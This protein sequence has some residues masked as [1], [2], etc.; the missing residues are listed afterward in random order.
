MGH[1]MDAIDVLLSRD[2]A[3][4]PPRAELASWLE[5]AARA[6]APPALRHEARWWE[7]HD[8]ALRS[9]W[10]RVTA[11]AGEGFGEPFSEREAVRLAL[12]H[13]ISGDVEE[14]QHVLAQAIQW[15]SDEGL[16]RRFADTCAAEGLAEA[17]GF[18]RR[19]AA[20]P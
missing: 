6:G 11:L 8:A 16:L 14:A 9:D 13:V 3:W 4:R 20:A 7:A 19:L 17:A 12:L 18:F 1:V 2:P 5:A 10:D 15:R